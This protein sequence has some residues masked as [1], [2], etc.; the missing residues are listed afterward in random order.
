MKIAI[1]YSGN[2]A[3]SLVTSSLVNLLKKKIYIEYS[4]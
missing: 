4:V 3:L 2:I 1:M